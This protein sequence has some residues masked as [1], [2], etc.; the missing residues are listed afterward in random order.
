MFHILILICTIVCWF[1]FEGSAWEVQLYGKSCLDGWTTVNMHHLC[2]IRHLRFDLG[3]SPSIPRVKTCSNHLRCFISFPKVRN[4]KTY[5]YQRKSKNFWFIGINLF[6]S[7]RSKKFSFVGINL[8]YSYNI[9]CIFS[10][11]R[12]SM[13]VRAFNLAPLRLLSLNC[14]L[15]TSSWWVSW[16]FT[17][18]SKK[19]GHS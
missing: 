6:Y 19:G 3:L 10:Q 7:Y 14:V 12:L 8:F 15:L 9:F 16:H 1:F 18:L 2:L 4:L 5:I 17:Q 13:L 11:E